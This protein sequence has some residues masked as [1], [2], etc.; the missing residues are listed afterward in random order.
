MADF[1]KIRRGS[2]GSPP[3]IEEASQN[4]QAPEVAPAAPE[5]VPSVLESAPPA[6]QPSAAAVDQP[7][8]TPR[9]SYVAPYQSNDSLRYASFSGVR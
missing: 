6:H 9:R 8:A 4:L 2:L 7:R 5:P 1:G 3:P